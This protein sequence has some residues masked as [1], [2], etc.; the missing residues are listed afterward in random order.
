MRVSCYFMSIYFTIV[1]S[2][3]DDCFV[4]LFHLS[5]GW[6]TGNDVEISAS[7]GDK[8]KTSSAHVETPF[9]LLLYIRHRAV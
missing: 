1:A 7:E 2:V 5:C 6:G 4:C 8:Q 9:S 3:W